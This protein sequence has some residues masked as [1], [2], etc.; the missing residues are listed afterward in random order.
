MEE[1]VARI[2]RDHRARLLALA[3]FER[4]TYTRQL[5]Y[6]GKGIEL[7]L[8]S[9]LPAQ[10]STIHDHAGATTTN[11][12]LTGSLIEERFE[13]TPGGIV[14]SG[15][16]RLDTNA[17]EALSASAIHRVRVVGDQPAVTLHLYM[18][19]YRIGRDYTGSEAR[20]AT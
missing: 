1:L 2:G 12:V 18:P 16:Q 17:V 3:R 13:R 6:R 11:I 14:L 8:V 19:G 5:A 9:W 10:G 20:C 7:W 15:T 4:D